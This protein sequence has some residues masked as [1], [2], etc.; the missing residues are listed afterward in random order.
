MNNLCYDY[1]Y[2]PCTVDD[3]LA[4][5]SCVIS[6]NLTTLTTFVGLNRPVEFHCQCMDSNGMMITGTR[7]LLPNGTAAPTQDLN[8]PPAVL[9]IPG[10]FAS[11]DAGTYICSP[12]NMANNPSRDTI[13]L[14]TGESEYFF[15]GRQKT[16]VHIHLINAV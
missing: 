16:I 7:W 5:T 13:D 2:Y 4:Q 10:R 11:S 9:Y 8:I 6:P 15:S 12:N 14:I 1:Y 3:V